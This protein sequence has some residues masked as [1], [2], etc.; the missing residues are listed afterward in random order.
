MVSK[1]LLENA[2]FAFYVVGILLIVWYIVQYLRLREVRETE[3]NLRFVALTDRF[4]SIEKL[5]MQYQ[6]LSSLA[7]EVYQKS[8]YPN[9]APKTIIVPAPSDSLRKHE[10]EFHACALM[11]QLMEDVWCVHNLSNKK[12]YNDPKMSGWM[13]LFYDWYNS[14]IFKKYFENLKYIYSKQFYDFVEYTVKNYT[15]ERDRSLVLSHS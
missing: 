9:E 11:I 12:N 3:H 14:N 7:R 5:F 2:Q 15:P 4:H 10:L 13:T 1:I 8:G 6:E